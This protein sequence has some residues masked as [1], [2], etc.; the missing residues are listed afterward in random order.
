MDYPMTILNNNT[1]G[2]LISSPDFGTVN[3]IIIPS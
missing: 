3:N 1:K 2:F